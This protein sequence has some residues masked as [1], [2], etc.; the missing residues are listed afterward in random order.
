MTGPDVKSV[1]A[2]GQGDATERFG[3]G[4]RGRLAVAQGFERRA[5]RIPT[6]PDQLVEAQDGELDPGVGR[7]VG[8]AEQPSP[9]R[10]SDDVAQAAAA[11][12]RR[13]R[14]RAS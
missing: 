3:S 7:D 1:D 2:N 14:A 9:L 13:P 12:L 6:R 8:R 4:S 10:A 11:R 5:D